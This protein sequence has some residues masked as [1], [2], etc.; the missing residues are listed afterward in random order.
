MVVRV[1]DLVSVG[2]DHHEDDLEDIPEEGE[3]IPSEA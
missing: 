3:T 1:A 2:Q